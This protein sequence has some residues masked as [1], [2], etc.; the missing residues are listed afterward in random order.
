MLQVLLS[1]YRLSDH[2]KLKFNE[3]IQ[4]IGFKVENNEVVPFV[5]E[6]ISPEL[7]NQLYAKIIN[8]L[9]KT[10][11]K[12]EDT[13]K[14]YMDSNEEKMRDVFLAALN[15]HDDL[16]PTGETF[17]RKG[18]TDIS[19]FFQNELVFI[20][21]CKMWYGKKALIEGINQLLGY[22]TLRNTKAALLIFNRNENFTE[23]LNKITETAESHKCYEEL[24][25]TNSNSFQYK[26]HHP[27]DNK[28]NINITFI[29]I[30]FV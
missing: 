27:D 3:A 6:E 25:Q 30:N 26:F 15:S 2:K 4:K 10:G 18:K 7:S 29:A 24:I 5:K 17:N 21:E 20:A 11:K 23:I 1:N 8:I 13:S 28:T 16:L 19:V 12:M 14:S 9:Y 22:L